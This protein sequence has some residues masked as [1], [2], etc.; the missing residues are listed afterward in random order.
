MNETFQAL[1]Q[2][3]LDDEYA[4]LN[5][6]QRQAV[7][8]TD[9]PLLILAGAGSGKTTVIINKIGY[10]IRYGHTYQTEPA[11]EADAQDIEFLRQCLQ[12]KS[13]RK[14]D[15]Y[16]Q[17]MA[18]KPIDAGHLLAI[19]FTNKA[20]QEM[21]TRLQTQFD[22]STDRLWALTFHSLCVRI[23]RNFIH[24]L[25][26]DRSFTIYDDSDSNKLMDG[27]IKDMGLDER[28]D[29]KAVRSAISRAKTAFV[30]AEEFDSVLKNS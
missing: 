19:T 9:A 24:L 7:F 29:V 2:K 16:M 6:M 18:E 17:L 1:R 21:R 8:F 12:D 4:H 23:L 5:D 10:L 14:T 15:R 30:S 28:Y 22:I 20:A 13:L 3:I 26:F 27:I 11:I 25:G